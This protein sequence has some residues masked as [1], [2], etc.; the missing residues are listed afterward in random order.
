MINWIGIKFTWGVTVA[1]KKI[2]LSNYVIV[3]KII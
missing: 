2:Y 3:Q 1:L